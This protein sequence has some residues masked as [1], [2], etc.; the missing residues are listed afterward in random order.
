M[1]GFKQL[2]SV[3]MVK[4]NGIRVRPSVEGD[5]SAPHCFTTLITAECFVN[6]SVEVA[7]DVQDV[8]KLRLGSTSKVAEMEVVRD[9]PSPVNHN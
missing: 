5:T 3:L 9:E 4:S 2:F 7:K 8:L 6:I 1:Y